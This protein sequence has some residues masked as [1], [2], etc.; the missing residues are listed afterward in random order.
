MN[1]RIA[2]KRLSAS[3]LTLF[4]YHFRQTSGTKQ[5]AFNLDK[6]VFIDRLYPSLPETVG[7]GRVQVDLSIYGP[8]LAGL[9][10]LQRKILKQQKNWRFD[11]ELIYNPPEEEDRYNVL[12]KGDFAIFDF[13]GEVEPRAARMYLI[14]QEDQCKALGFLDTFLVVSPP[15][16]RMELIV[17][18]G[19]PAPGFCSHGAGE[20]TAG[21][22]AA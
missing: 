21:C 18:P 15:P 14:A 1:R 13:M 17:C 4:E 5:K 20:S 9:D 22:I 11:G 7:S 19:A 8:G 16:P 10:N 6:S 2:L 12:S 3:D